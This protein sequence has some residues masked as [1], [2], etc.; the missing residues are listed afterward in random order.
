MNHFSSLS[1][2]KINNLLDDELAVLSKPWKGSIPFPAYVINVYDVVNSGT[3]DKPPQD[4]DICN[5]LDAQRYPIKCL[6]FCPKKY[7]PPLEGEMS[8]TKQ[9]IGWVDLKRDLCTSAHSAGN[10]IICNGSN[11]RSED[12]PQLMHFKYGGSKLKKSKAQEV[13]ATNQYR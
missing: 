8:V 12:V 6:Y 4:I 2:T 10:P 1:V 11:R 3:F 13:T 9:C 5:I 7:P